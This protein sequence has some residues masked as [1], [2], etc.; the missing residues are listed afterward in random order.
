MT[1]TAAQIREARRLLRRSSA[2]LAMTSGVG[3]DLV[4]KAQL[5]AEIGSVDP[6]ALDVIK[7]TLTRAGIDFMPSGDVQLRKT[8]PRNTEP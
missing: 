4:L 8:R 7:Q 2:R 5:D 1:V 3:F 6:G